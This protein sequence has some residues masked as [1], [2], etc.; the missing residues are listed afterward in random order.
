[1]ALSPSQKA[2]Y[3]RLF[4]SAVLR[5]MAS[6]RKSPLFTRLARESGVLDLGA[7]LD[8]VRDVFEAAFQMLKKGSSRDEYIYKAALTQRV[9]LGRHNLRSASML[10][11]F[12]AGKSKADLAILNGTTTVY[13]IKSERDKLSRLT[14][15]IADY[16]RVFASVFVI[17]GE[18][19][20][21]AVLKAMSPDVGV[22]CLSKRYSIST[23]R[24]A[25]NRPDRIC[26]LTVFDAIRTTEACDVLR[27]LGEAVPNVPNTMMHRALRA[28]F[29][30]LKP[31]DVHTA[32]LHT[33]KQSR[34]QLP[35]ADL[36]DRMPRS[37]CAAALTVPLRKCDH[38][39]L[40]EAID[41]PLKR[42]M[43]WA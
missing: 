43:A 18:N 23:V 5:E 6:K 28:L 34:S 14:G 39:R 40:V 33:L 15:Q 2:A 13:E 37:L 9:L 25:E 27:Y 24:D 35:L 7:P 21:E 11:E 10:T 19:H 1:M 22:M 8:R 4:S 41:A 32:M 17:A 3:S 16:K 26:P 30:R 31:V 38:D 12:R 20:V 29:E 36:V 42:A